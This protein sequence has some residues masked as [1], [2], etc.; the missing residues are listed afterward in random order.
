MVIESSLVVFG[1][2]DDFTIKCLTRVLSVERVLSKKTKM[3][4]T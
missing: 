2:L 1:V 3:F 4:N